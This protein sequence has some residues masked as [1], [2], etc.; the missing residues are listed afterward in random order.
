MEINPLSTQEIIRY[1]AFYN[2]LND[3]K[4]NGTKIGK[5][6]A[7]SGLLR[8]YYDED[9]L[10]EAM[11]E[12]DKPHPAHST[13]RSAI[14]K[15][16]QSFWFAFNLN[17]AKLKGNLQIRTA[18]GNLVDCGSLGHLDIEKLRQQC[19]QASFGDLQTM[20][21]KI[22]LDVRSG[23]T[24]DFDK[25]L[26]TKPVSRKVKMN[27][28]DD[29]YQ[30]KIFEGLLQQVQEDF[31]DESLYLEPYR[32]NV[33]EQGGFFKAHVDTPR[34]PNMLG[35]M[36][37]ALEKGEGGDLVLRRGDQVY[38]EKN[39]KSYEY[40]TF[41]TAF[42][43]DIAHEIT[44]VVKGKRVALTF[45]I[46]KD[47]EAVPKSAHAITFKRQEPI[48]KDRNI[49]SLIAAIKASPLKKV[50]ILTEFDYTQK[51]ISL[52]SLKGNDRVVF[53]ELS[54]EPEFKVELLPVVVKH[55]YSDNSSLDESPQ[56][57]STWGTVFRFLTED[58]DR[59][60]RGEKP[61]EQDQIAFFWNK[62]GL[63]VYKHKQKGAEH[64]G[65]ESLDNAV[66]NI[67]FNAAM[68]ITDASEKQQIADLDIGGEYSDVSMDD[69]DE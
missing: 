59:M 30:R 62:K 25:I 5:L 57:W 41:G 7:E 22:D 34:Y 24:I 39:N 37:L 49:A 18:E 29:S 31:Q 32:L 19:T 50:G 42:F 12:L 63:E 46:C 17:C 1:H 64:T 55:H 69:Y 15:T 4:K 9:D 26:I 45:S 36:V 38:Q 14:Q 3:I 60:A 58:M 6:P 67:Y 52:H 66:D 48:V 51:G 8:D 53:E 27:A 13:L 16:Y 2:L 28:T 10:K 11:E 44:P 43:C 35:T 65:N 23:L 68:V 54:K 21:T 20:T 40:S 47:N 61:T 33:Y 56:Y